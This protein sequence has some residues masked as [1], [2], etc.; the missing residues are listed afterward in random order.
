MDELNRDNFTFTPIT[1]STLRKKIA[2]LPKVP[3]VYLFKDA[4]GRVLYVGK[5]ID[6]RSRVSSYFQPSADLETTRGP[7]IVEMVKQTVTL[8]YIECENEVQALL[9]EN[10]LI[11]DIQPPYNERM[12]DGKSYPYLEITTQDEYPMVMITREPNPKSKLFGPF[13]DSGGLRAAYREMQKVFKFCTCRKITSEDIAKNRPRPCLLYSIKLCSGAC[14]GMISK[15]AYREDIKRLIKFLSGSRTGVVKEMKTRMAEAVRELRYEQAAKLRDQ[16]KALES[17]SLSGKPD[18]DLQPEVF[19]QDPKDGL[20]KLAKLLNLKDPPRIIEGFD[21]ANLQGGEACG[22]LVQFID[23]MVFKGGYKRFKIKYTAN[24]SDDYGM[25]KE[26]IAR[27]YKHVAAGEDLVP[28]LILVD[29]GPGQ[30]NAA[31][32]AFAAVPITPPK[33]I[34][35]AKKEEEI[36]T[37]GEKDPIKL[38]RNDP[39]LKLLQRIRDEAHRFAQHYHHI[40][41]R[42]KV[43]GEDP[44]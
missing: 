7:R 6:L 1:V 35:L 4:Q 19:F 28:D 39:A 37:G 13:I 8:D 10:R 33:I 9:D 24:H 42:K 36:Y 38:P 43:M 31:R 15:E 18:L 11:K 30:L 5:S 29:G 14:A 32:E 27:R 44:D 25:M 16:I 3:G 23:G 40:L 34:S 17:L 21:I 12:T 22:S 41:R 20:K 2:E 26:V